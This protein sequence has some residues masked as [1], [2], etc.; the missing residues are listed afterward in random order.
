MTV[1]ENA[2]HID[3]SPDDVWAVLASLDLLERYD[4]GVEK[5]EIISPIRTG[6]GAARRCTL[7]PGGRG[8]FKERITVWKPDEALEFELFECSLPVRNL[9][10]SYLLR[11]SATGTTVHQ[12]MEY[13]LRY[14]LA[15]RMLDRMLVRSRWS[16][17]V[18]SF[19]EGLKHHVESIRTQGAGR[20]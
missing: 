10:H 7:R 14:G 2:I 12:R 17:G 18:R 1:L 4:P 5:S 15:G 13:S 8:W 11:R 19:M 3:A 6:L 16:S 9:R 20:A